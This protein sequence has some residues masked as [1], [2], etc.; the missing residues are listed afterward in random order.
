MEHVW[1]KTQAGA[2]P[3]HHGRYAEAIVGWEHHRAAHVEL[4]AAQR[5]APERLSSL[6]PRQVINLAQG[7]METLSS[8]IS[9]PHRRQGLKHRLGYRS[10]CLR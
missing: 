8:T 10:N 1:E 4:N 7:L 2:T 6:Y 3:A 5:K 9:R